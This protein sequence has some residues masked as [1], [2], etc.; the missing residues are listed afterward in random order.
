[1]STKFF[2]N[3]CYIWLTFFTLTT[4]A[5][6]A[7]GIK[8]DTIDEEYQLGSVSNSSVKA[9]L[10]EKFIS[11]LLE[12]DPLLRAERLL[13][14]IKEDPKNSEIPSI[15]FNISLKKQEH[16]SRMVNKFSSVWKENLTNPIITLCG[17][18]LYNNAAADSATLIKIM[19]DVKINYNPSKHQEAVIASQI[20]NLTINNYRNLADFKR[21]KKYI[22]NFYNSSN[23]S[24]AINKLIYALEFLYTQEFRN[25]INDKNYSDIT[26]AKEEYI[27]IIFDIVLKSNLETDVQKVC[28]FFNAVKDSKNALLLAK[29]YCNNDI[30]KKNLLYNVIV[31]TGNIDELTKTLVYFKDDKNLIFSNYL[32]VKTLIAGKKYDEALSIAKNIKVKSIQQNCLND[33]NNA[34]KD[35]KQ[36]A[37]LLKDNP[38]LLVRTPLMTLLLTA[39]Y[40]LDKELFIKIL[41]IIPPLELLNNP[42]LA[43]GV[44][45][46]S[47]ILDYDLDNATKLIERA[48]TKSPYNAAFLDSMAYVEYK[49]GNYN[50]AAKYRAKSLELADFTIGCGVL[51][52]HAG[53]IERK[54][55]NFKLALKFYE[56]ALQYGIPSEDF[57][58][59]NVRNKINTIKK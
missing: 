57:K 54:R 9:Q 48:L 27:K 30:K 15:Y 52:E 28:F 37:K 45:Y 56:K 53:D 51:F 10:L 42:I 13:E 38:K 50:S 59:E 4:F 20:F 19:D 17:L 41:K 36:L 34:K 26:N 32:K 16:A 5:I 35:Y 8:N 31:E 58:P 2:K 40:T 3:L 44:G 6:D 39:E 21:A 7:I 23:L 22:S 1:M 29:K 14:I 43:N 33:I 12:K 25:K 11:A 24:I 46:I 49:K 47:T 55:N 18:R